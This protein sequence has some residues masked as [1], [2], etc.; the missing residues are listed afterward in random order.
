MKG[1]REQTTES[2]EVTVLRKKNKSNKIVPK[3]RERDRKKE[4]HGSSHL[5]H[6][7]TNQ[8]NVLYR[9]KKYIYIL[10]LI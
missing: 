7:Q 9:N 4:F 6:Q 5:W 8:L 2:M 10:Y 3:E 1:E